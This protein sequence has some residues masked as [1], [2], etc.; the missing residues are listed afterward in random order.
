MTNSNEQLYPKNPILLV[1]D[2]KS[3]LR[4]YELAL[5]SHGINNVISCSSGAQAKEI[6]G[7]QDIELIILDMMIPDIPGNELL[8]S[9]TEQYPEI[10]IIMATCIDSMEQAIECIHSGAV[11]YM[12]KPVNINKLLEKICKH[13]EIN[14]LKR[15]NRRLK[16]TLLSEGEFKCSKSFATIITNNKYMYTLFR[17]CEAIAASNQPILITGETGVGKELFAKALHEESKCQ[18]KLVTVNIAGL[19]DNMI[20]D[21]LF[22]HTKGAFTGAVDNRAGVVEKASNG[23]LFIDEI[24][25]LNTASQ[26]KLLRLLQQREYLPLGSDKVKTSS[27]RVILATHRDLHELQRDKKFRQDLYYRIATHHIEIPPLRDRSDDI[28]LLLNFFIAKAA[29]E[30]NRQEPDYPNE[31][32]K[33]L[34]SYNFPGNVRELEAMVYDAVISN[35]S[36]KLSTKVFSAHIKRN[37]NPRDISN[38]TNPEDLSSYF[39]SLPSL[40]EA[41]EFNEAL[42]REAINRAAGNKSVAAEM[43]GITPQALSA[44]VK[45][46]KTQ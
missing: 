33:L 26:V 22:G 19:D 8:D 39:S 28:I 37:S 4:S 11:D 45:K 43:L 17:Y 10:P 42:T 38:I 35:K 29:K 18:G 5:L 3:I 41:K 36:P 21:T 15:E 16:N 13:I 46:M 12:V 23:T 44:R 31:L 34:K 9:F 20:S 25:D 6:V 14:E 40:P 2:E 27:A 1:D 30:L 7:T 32:V 24:G